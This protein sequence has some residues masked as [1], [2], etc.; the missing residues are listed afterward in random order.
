[1][2][3]RIVNRHYAESLTAP[4]VFMCGAGGSLA[5]DLIHAATVEGEDADVA[6][7][8]ELLPLETS[9]QYAVYRYWLI[10]LSLRG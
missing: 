3:D 6:E 4:S 2:V 7:D 8:L 9:I 10:S 1:M 5:D